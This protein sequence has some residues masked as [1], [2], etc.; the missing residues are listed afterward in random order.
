M[1][2]V[3]ISETL[4]REGVFTKKERKQVRVFE[5]DYNLHDRPCQ[6]VVTSVIGHLMELEVDPKYTSWSSCDPI[7]IFD[8]PVAKYIKDVSISLSNIYSAH[9]FNYK[10]LATI[11]HSPPLPLSFI[12]WV[13]LF[14]P[15]SQDNLDIGKTLEREA[16]QCQELVLWLDC[17]REGE[18]ISFEVC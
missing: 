9:Y 17:D 8:V 18:N 10:F 14:L 13:M 15:A 3:L 5:F 4:Q 16:R 7:E 12:F 2:T 6:M 1:N 11:P